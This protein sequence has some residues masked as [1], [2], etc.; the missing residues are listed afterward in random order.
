MALIFHAGA[1]TTGRLFQ[2]SLD[3][4]RRPLAITPLL[5]DRGRAYHARLSPDG[6]LVAFDSDRDGERGV[7]V[8]SRD[9]SNVTRVSED[10]FAAVPSWSPDNKWLAFVRAEP[11]RP[12]V[13][14]LWLRDLS[15]GALKRQSAFRSGQ[16][17][18]ASWFPDSRT[19]CYS[20]EDRLIVGDLASGKTTSFKSPIPGRLMRTPAVAPDG[21]L[22]VFQVYRD[23][24]WVLDVK[25][26][27]MRRWLADPTAEEFAWDPD[28]RRIAYH[29]RR[30]GQ[31]RIWM[32]TI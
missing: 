13:W 6:G 22:I 11:A 25:T 28:G 14:N 30:D 19:L 16:V 31:W 18:G 20:H 21:R 24:V 27:E 29:S 32:L 17:W 9:G 10:G 4:S 8:A 2:A 5:E 12:K 26:G 7:Y 15:T 23:G 3:D 1:N